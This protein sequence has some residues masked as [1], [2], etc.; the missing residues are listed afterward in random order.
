MVSAQVISTVLQKA[1]EVATHSWEYGTV[2]EALLEWDTPK[3]SIWNNPFPGGKV[4]TLDV[5]NTSAL[6]YIKSFII[7]TGP[8]LV[9]GDGAAGDPASLG[10]PALQIGKSDQKYWDAA[11]RQ[12][13]HLVN[14]VPRWDNGAISHREAYPE[15]WA[16]FVYMVPPF[17]AYYGVATSS[18]SVMKEAAQQCKHYHD[19]LVQPSGAWLHI[20]GDHTKDYA[21]WSTGNAWA[22]A[23]MSRV[24]ATLKKSPLAAQVASEQTM[25]RGYV[26]E[27]LDASIKF[28]ND[29][30]GLLRNYLNDTMW[31]GEISGTSLLAATALRM[32]KLEPAT[33]GKNYV[34]WAEKKMKVVDGKIDSSNGIVAPAIN[35][36][37][38]HDMNKY[39][40]GSPEGQS[41][42]VLLH[43]AWRDLK[44]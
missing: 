25:V 6:K 24:F 7:T 38:W 13:N 19:A 14:D 43:A 16:D 37:D 20:I 40:S 36:L 8:T 34:D 11:I 35:P 27:I 30:S 23:G 18:V 44:G 1:V 33:F 2:G 4:P 3:L 21:L 26:K 9:D 17:M 32:A 29:S 41:F 15:L 22:A 42:V 28:D 12:Y 10:I 39:V 5:T 31:W